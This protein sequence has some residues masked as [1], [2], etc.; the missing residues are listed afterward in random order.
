[1]IIVVIQPKS[2]S[3]VLS[4]SFHHIPLSCNTSPN[5]RPAVTLS[6]NDCGQYNLV[7]AK[8]QWRCVTGKVTVGQPAAGFAARVIYGLMGCGL[9]SARAQTSSIN[10]ATAFTFVNL[11]LEYNT[12]LWVD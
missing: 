9:E 8:G 7:E 3:N 12:K 10:D 6:R 5:S 2:S 11:L 1:M 4:A